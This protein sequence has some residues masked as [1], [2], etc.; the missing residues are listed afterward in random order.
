MEQ[1]LASAHGDEGV[2]M[3]TGHGGFSITTVPVHRNAPDSVLNLGGAS[4]V[5]HWTKV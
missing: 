1:A 3:Q 2:G 4:E 5:V